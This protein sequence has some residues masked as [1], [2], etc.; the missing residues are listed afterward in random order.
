M[1]YTNAA[2]NLHHHDAFEE[3]AIDTIHTLLLNDGVMP[4]TFQCETS[5][6]K[7]LLIL[8]FMTEQAGIENKINIVRAMMLLHNVER[9]IFASETLIP[10]KQGLNPYEDENA[11]DGL[12][13]FHADKHGLKKA[14]QYFISR[15]N[16]IIE[17]TDKT[18]S[19]SLKTN[20]ELDLLLAGPK[21]TAIQLKELE[22]IVSTLPPNYPVKVFENS[23]KINH[24]AHVFN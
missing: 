23:S 11:K 5:D 6:N 22:M 7:Q 24:Q 21:V 19:E 18:E 16:N 4:M 17:L 15:K 1:S 2:L 14:T 3:H 8:Y 20:T 9:Y 12:V 10:S 13:F